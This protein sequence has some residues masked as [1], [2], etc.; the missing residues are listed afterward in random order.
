MEN[1]FHIQPL[2]QMTQQTCGTASFR[3]FNKSRR[4]SSVINRYCALFAA[5]VILTMATLTNAF[6]QPMS[7]IDHPHHKVTDTKMCDN[8]IKINGSTNVNHFYFFQKLNDS[9]KIIKNKDSHSN[10]SLEILI[11]AYDFE[12]SNPM[13]YD[14]FL[15]F[16][17]AGEYPN[18][19]ITI[20]F[21]NPKLPAGGSGNIAP[22]IKIGLAGQTHIYK[23]PGQLEECRE[24]SLHIS[25]KV[26]IDLKDFGLEPPS[27]FMGMVK[28]KNEVFINFGLTLK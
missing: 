19:E 8:F 6:G 5:V 16:I 25:A 2:S 4:V 22:R 23:I 26:N 13:M 24:N 12:P 27:K 20:F 14:D 7:K 3:L 10:E 9:G 15:E 1:K 11:P 21:N 17:K 28:V 18:I